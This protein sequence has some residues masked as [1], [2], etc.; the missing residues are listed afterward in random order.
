MPS[1]FEAGARLTGTSITISGSSGSEHPP[2]FRGARQGA[3][4]FFPSPR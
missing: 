2:G 1:L 3:L 4:R